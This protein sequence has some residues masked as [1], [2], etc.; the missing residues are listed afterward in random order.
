MTPAGLPPDWRD[1]WDERAGLVEEGDGMRRDDAESIALEMTL[2][3]MRRVGALKPKQED[4][5][6]R[7]R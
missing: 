3:E 4:L 2:R 1:W 6:T 5:F 7:R